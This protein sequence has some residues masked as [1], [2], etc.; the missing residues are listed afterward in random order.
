[1][2]ETVRLRDRRR[3][4]RRLRAGR[5]AHRGRAHS[6]LLLEYGGSDR[7]I[8]IQMPSALS[9]RWA[10][11]STTGATTPSPSRTSAG[12][13]CTRR[14]ARCS[15]APPRSTAWCT[16]AATRTISSAGRSKARR[17]GTM[18][19]VL[20]YFRRAETRA[21]GGDDYRGDDGPLGTRY[22]TLAQSAARGLARGRPAGRLPAHARTSTATSR[23]A[24]ARLDMTVDG[25]RRS[26]AA[27]A[28]LRPAMRRAEPHGAHAR[29]RDAHPVRRPPRGRR[30]VPARRRASRGA[31]TARSAAERRVDQLAAA[32]EALG[33]RAGARSWPSTALR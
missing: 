10:W 20:P 5:P 9:S 27:N 24:S 31:R 33:R 16:C 28:Y 17:A 22:G 32:A 8:F 3:G 2:T 19:D 23:K 29:A 25:G 21:G 15:A 11:R 26:S 4:L 12:G 13:A 30:D 7:S 6:V 14:A 18:R 1:M